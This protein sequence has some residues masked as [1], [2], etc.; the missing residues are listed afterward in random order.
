MNIRLEKSVPTQRIDNKPLLQR[1]ISSYQIFSDSKFVFKLTTTYETLTRHEYST[2]GS[3]NEV[4]STVTYKRVPSGDPQM[5]KLSKMHHI[6][7]RGH[8]ESFRGT[9]Y[10]VYA[11]FSGVIYNRNK[12]QYTG[13]EGYR[14]IPRTG[15]TTQPIEDYYYTDGMYFVYQ[16]KER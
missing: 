2:D 13:F 11:L 3:T 16:K 14:L 10:D 8:T 1:G 9:R 15:F 7:K 12:P 6:L 4:K 5:L